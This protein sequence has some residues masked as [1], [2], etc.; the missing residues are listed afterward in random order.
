MDRLVSLV[1]GSAV[2]TPEDDADHA[3]PNHLVED[4]PQR[5]WSAHDLT[6][7]ELVDDEWIANNTK[8]VE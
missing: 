7:D 5:G 8:V 2:E 1:T 6:E 3:A 4:G